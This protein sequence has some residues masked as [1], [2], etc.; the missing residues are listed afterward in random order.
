MT[1]KFLQIYKNVTTLHFISRT[2]VILEMHSTFLN[3]VEAELSAIVGLFQY[4]ISSVLSPP[5]IFISMHYLIL[6]INWQ[7]YANGFWCKCCS[8]LFVNRGVRHY[9][10]LA[11]NQ[12]FFLTA[13][14]D[15]IRISSSSQQSWRVDKVSIL[16]YQTWNLIHNPQYVANL[17]LGNYKHYLHY[18]SC[19]WRTKS[20]KIGPHF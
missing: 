14:Q 20:N 12:F 19:W 16:G 6:W 3:N 9:C 17:K 5:S 8:T 7:A 15:C 4:C 11:E 1:T 13:E 2:T 18:P 10:T